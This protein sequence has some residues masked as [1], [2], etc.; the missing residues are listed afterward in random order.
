MNIINLR[1]KELRQDI[2]RLNEL[3]QQTEQSY[4]RL[5]SRNTITRPHSQIQE[6]I[7]KEPQKVGK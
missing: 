2:Q 7:P 1:L 6:N 3:K 5:I 4:L